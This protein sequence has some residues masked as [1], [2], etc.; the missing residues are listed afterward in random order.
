MDKENSRLTPTQAPHR[1]EIHAQRR[2]LRSRRPFRHKPTFS[3]KHLNL[4][5]HIAPYPYP[6]N[7]HPKPYTV[8]GPSIPPIR[9]PNLGV[10]V[11]DENNLYEINLEFRLLINHSKS[12][13]LPSSTLELLI[14]GRYILEGC[15]N[16]A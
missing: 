3:F 11:L 7:P 2:A 9:H 13:I 14:D 12:S 5:L 4:A 15:Q 8:P 10:L 6:P 16:V 1:T